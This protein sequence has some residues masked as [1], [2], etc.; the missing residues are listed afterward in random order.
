MTQEQTNL[1]VY[2]QVVQDKKHKRLITSNIT[3]QVKVRYDC[4]YSA[5][6]I[7]DITIWWN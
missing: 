5:H 2:A 3:L 7:N 6:I 1:D 4:H